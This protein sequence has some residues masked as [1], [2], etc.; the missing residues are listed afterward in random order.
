LRTARAQHIAERAGA[1]L[2]PNDF[3]FNNRIE[4]ISAAVYAELEPAVFRPFADAW[5]AKPSCAG[6]ATNGPMSASGKKRTSRHA[7]PMSAF[8]GKADIGRMRPDRRF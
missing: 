2:I 7:Q 3:F 6:N 8:G 4:Q 1:L 5:R